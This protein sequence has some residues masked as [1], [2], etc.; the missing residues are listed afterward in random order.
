MVFPF[1]SMFSS[2]SSA[3]PPPT[4][5]FK[6]RRKSSSASTAVSFDDYAYGREGGTAPSSSPLPPSS[7]LLTPLRAGRSQGYGESDYGIYS[8]VHKDMYDSEDDF[9][10]VRNP[11]SYDIRREQASRFR[12]PSLITELGGHT[13]WD[14]VPLS[15]PESPPSSTSPQSA[16]CLYPHGDSAIADDGE[17]SDLESMDLHVRK[18]YFATSAE[19]GRWKSSPIAPRTR[20]QATF[21]SSPIRPMRGHSVGRDGLSDTPAS[22]ERMRRQSTDST[23]NTE[24]SISSFFEDN[25]EDARYSSPLPPSSPL[26]SPMSAAPS[27]PDDCEDDMAVDHSV[28]LL[29]VRDLLYSVTVISPVFVFILSTYRQINCPPAPPQLTIRHVTNLHAPHVHLVS[30]NFLPHVRL[31]ALLLP[32]PS[33][34]LSIALST[35][36]CLR[37]PPGTPPV[38]NRTTCVHP[39]PYLSLTTPHR[40]NSPRYPCRIPR[41]NLTLDRLQPI[42]GSLLMG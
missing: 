41:I 11:W 14:Q 28:S 21:V 42:L 29:D 3:S 16:S 37:L 2:P 17:E 25:D 36:R 4:I 23:A 31:V 5:P 19:R 34:T 8:A 30:L 12:L 22:Q 39:C 32:S 6:F 20:L 24:L 10:D 9:E 33:K 26:T 38:S 27:L 15:F 1:T 35:T 40:Q 7:P 13:P 18:T